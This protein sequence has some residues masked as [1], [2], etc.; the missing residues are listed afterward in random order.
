M[1]LGF[2]V[3]GVEA[4]I[5]ANVNSTTAEVVGDIKKVKAE[6]EGK[7][8]PP[9]SGLVPRDLS[10]FNEIE[11]IDQEGYLYVDDGL[12]GRRIS[13]NT[14]RNAGKD[15]II[16]DYNG[17]SNRPIINANLI[18]TSNPTTGVYYRHVGSTN[19]TY[20]KGVIYYYDGESYHSIAAS[21]P[22][23]EKGQSNG[24]ATLN[25]SGIVPS[26]QLPT[27]PTTTAQ[28]Q[29]NSGYVTETEVDAK[30]EEFTNISSS[31]I[32]AVK[33]LEKALD[34]H[35]D[36]YDSL[37]QQVSEKASKKYVDNEVKVK[38]QHYIAK[39]SFTITTG[40]SLLSMKWV[41]NGVDGITQPFAG[42]SLKIQIPAISLL[43]TGAVLSIDGGQTFHPVMQNRITNLTNMYTEES[44]VEFFYNDTAT[45]DV[46]LESGVKVT[47]T[48]C[49]Q[50]S[51]YNA[52]KAVQQTSTSTNT[53]L[54]LLL[55]PVD[56][57]T[58]TTTTTQAATYYS[59][60]V[61][62]NPATGEL[63]AKDF[64]IEGNSV[65]GMLG[66]G[67]GG[68]GTSSGMPVIRLINVST[69]DRSGIVSPDLPVRV[70]IQVLDGSILPTDE[71]QLCSRKAMT[72][73]KYDDGVEA[74]PTKT[75]GRRWRYRR[76]VGKSGQECH[77]DR[78]MENG[79]YRMICWDEG[80]AVS[81]RQF[82]RS[83]NYYKSHRVVTKYIRV[84]RM[85]D[86]TF[87]HS[88][89]IPIQFCIEDLVK[90][91]KE[92]AKISVR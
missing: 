42:M 25:E 43:N 84:S 83:D 86:E 21:I 16:T 17:L 85:I 28:L 68:G 27:I 67:S 45:K 78:S 51:D 5:K 15:E 81:A 54:P 6:I 77:P 23:A 3:D 41:V 62:V 38:G 72:Y 31:T 44:I 66:G 57:N 58:T 82:L 1:S 35:A 19:A 55:R 33:E 88:N 61:W 59:K 12:N 90:P 40:T 64:L 18:G 76:I 8:I 56:A 71:I 32:E 53:P 29:N 11:E 49:W 7:T 87:Y 89:A 70:T 26:T 74:E 37:L 30:L 92:E 75:R 50:V 80:D 39:D 79:I 48:G 22:L 63:N 69:Y 14:I 65:L 46:Y 47:L 20:T 13:L 9:V 4:T 91:E 34:E 73:A 52:D 60:Y 24:V 10:K 36:E 2:D